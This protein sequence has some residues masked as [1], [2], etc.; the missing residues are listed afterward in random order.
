MY[1]IFAGNNRENNL[2]AC[3]MFIFYFV[4]FATIMLDLENVVTFCQNC[5]CDYFWVK[6]GINVRK[7]NTILMYAQLQF[8]DNTFTTDTTDY[9]EPQ[10]FFAQ[11]GNSAY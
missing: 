5:Y 9:L 4:N 11:Y 1:H 10:R 8:Y 7:T 3:S 6:C 2:I